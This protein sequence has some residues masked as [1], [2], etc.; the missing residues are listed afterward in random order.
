MAVKRIGLFGNFGGGNLGN[1]GTLEAMLLF[2]RQAC[3]DA[4]LICICVEPD[5]VKAQYGIRAFAVRP[6]RLPSSGIARIRNKIADQLYLFRQLGEVDIL[7]IPGTGVMDDFGERPLGFPYSV[8]LTCL[9]AWLRRRKIAFVSV[10]AGPIR[11]PV[12]RWLMKMAARMASYRSYRDVISKQ[13]MESIGLNVGNDPVYPDL[14]FSLPDPEPRPEGKNAGLTVGLGVMAYY[15]WS[16]KGDEAIYQLYLKKLTEF[17]IW[18]LNN[19]Y[20]IRLL[21]GEHTDQRA[22]D[23]LTRSIME[24]CGFLS[25]DRL[26]ADIPRS[27]HELMTQIAAADAVVA[28]RFHNVLCALKVGTPTISLGYAEKNDVLM[29]SMGLGEFC[30]HVERFEVDWLIREFTKLMERRETY[31]HIVRKHNAGLRNQLEQQERFLI[32][33]FM[34]D[35][36]VPA[37]GLSRPAST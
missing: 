26:V 19:G 5:V 7:L 17:S 23:D 10:G 22:V 30:R 9:M 21:V 28:T 20:S 33:N 11:H 6:P 14:A 4:E 2:L 31:R 8:F 13:F 18:L 27:L 16:A 29:A 25:A 35:V 15:G 32:A 1:E 37:Q 3:P 12:S 24:R 36:N 34:A